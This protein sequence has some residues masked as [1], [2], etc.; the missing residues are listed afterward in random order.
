[1]AEKPS[2]RNCSSQGK[3]GKNDTVERERIPA[4]NRFGS[5]QAPCRYSRKEK[6]KNGAYCLPEI[7]LIFSGGAILPRSRI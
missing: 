3:G 1:M 5:Q 2:A 4:G 6:A 7:H